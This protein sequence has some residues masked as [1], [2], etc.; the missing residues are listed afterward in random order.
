MYIVHLYIRAHNVHGGTFLYISVLR[1]VTDIFV[2]SFL[3]L[4]IYI[5]MKGPKQKGAFSLE[6]LKI[7]FFSGSERKNN[8][9][10]LELVLFQKLQIN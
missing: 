2:R 7:G 1:H 4:L 10:T 5:Y 6:N 9:E 8:E 3:V